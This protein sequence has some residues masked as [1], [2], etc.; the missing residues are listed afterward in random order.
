MDGVSTGE[1]N[2]NHAME[3]A[4]ITKL[5]LNGSTLVYS[6]YLTL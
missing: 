1:H 3:N 2:H 5:F 6:F 4:V